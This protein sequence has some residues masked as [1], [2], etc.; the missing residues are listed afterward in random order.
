MFIYE[1]YIIPG[2]QKRQE[3]SYMEPNNTENSGKAHKWRLYN[4]RS[5]GKI[6][7]FIYGTY[8]IPRA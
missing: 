6:G 8:I 4:I 3:C 2:A 5:S 1:P 7:V